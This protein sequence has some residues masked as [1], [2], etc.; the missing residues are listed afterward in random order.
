MHISVHIF[1]KVH[2]S[3]HT[4]FKV[5]ISV[6]TFFKVHISV[7]TNKSN[8]LLKD[9]LVSRNDEKFSN[10]HFIESIIFNWF[11]KLR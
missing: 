7:R 10:E 6:H 8:L 2:I 4:F 11:E 5:H 9:I 3:V 1:F